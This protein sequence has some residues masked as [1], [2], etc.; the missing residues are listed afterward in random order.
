M[1]PKS[2]SPFLVKANYDIKA[3]L[4]PSLISGVLSA[5]GFRKQ[6]PMNL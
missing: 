3:P 4:N 5:K 6:T 2:L 1:N